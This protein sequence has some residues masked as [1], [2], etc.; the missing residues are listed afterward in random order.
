MHVDANANLSLLTEKHTMT[1]VRFRQLKDM[2]VFN[3]RSA[4]A[5]AIDHYGFPAPIELGK[6]TLAWRL[7]DDVE[8]WIASRER[9]VPKVNPSPR[10]NRKAA[11]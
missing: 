8:P 4:L 2:A 9:W 11:S 1:L 3:D 7:E 5:R 10:G 6:N